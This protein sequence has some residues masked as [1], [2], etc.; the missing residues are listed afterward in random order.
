VSDR[1][2]VERFLASP[3]LSEA[4]RRAYRVDVAEFAAWLRRH[5]QSLEDVDARTLSA[6]TAE[7]GAAQR[8]RQPSKLAPAT[9]ARK[10]AAV[11][12]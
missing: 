1:A 6:Y 12:A 2:F 4:T 7:L 3:E 9:I 10:L 5:G 8:S 11:R